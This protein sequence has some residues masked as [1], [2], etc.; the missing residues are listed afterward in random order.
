MKRGLPLPEPTGVGVTIGAGVETETGCGG[1]VKGGS[2]IRVRVR[3]IGVMERHGCSGT[4][5]L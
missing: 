3:P 2:I 1:G 4:Y 5:G